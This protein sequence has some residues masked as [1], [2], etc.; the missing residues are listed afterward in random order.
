MQEKAKNVLKKFLQLE[1][2]VF[3]TQFGI[4]KA[5]RK[6]SKKKDANYFYLFFCW[7]IDIIHK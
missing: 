2:G 3:E 5:S 4:W 7:I 6:I 1:H